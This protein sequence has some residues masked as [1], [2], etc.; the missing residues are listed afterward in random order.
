MRMG[1][2]EIIGQV[3]VAVAVNMAIQ[4]ALKELGPDQARKD[5]VAVSKNEIQK[6]GVTLPCKVSILLD[7]SSTATK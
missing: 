2:A 6:L 3:K 4:G 7:T 5:L 1:V